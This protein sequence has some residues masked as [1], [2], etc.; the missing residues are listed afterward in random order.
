MVLLWLNCAERPCS[1]NAGPL[2]A[3]SRAWRGSQPV[4]VRGSAAVDEQRT[5]IHAEQTDHLH[6]LQ[7]NKTSL[8]LRTVHRRAPEVS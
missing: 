1:L 5:G 2:H 8:C 6:L 4:T 3:E 7:R